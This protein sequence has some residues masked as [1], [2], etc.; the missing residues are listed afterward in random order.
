LTDT[1]KVDGVAF[2]L[3][4]SSVKFQMRLETSPTLK[5]N[6]T[7]QI[8]LATAGTVRYDWAAIDVD[9]AGTYIGWWE[10]TLA[11]G[12]TQN[13]P[14]FVLVVKDADPAQILDYVDR[15]DLKSTL[16]LQGFTYADAD[17]DRAISAA[18]RGIDEVT[19]RR[20]Y[21]DAD[22]LQVRYYTPRCS[23]NLWID[24][25]I[26]L[27]SLKTDQNGDGTFEITWTLTTDFLLEPLNAILNGRPFNHV[28]LAERGTKRFYNYRRS[29]E[30]TGKFG[31]SSPPEAVKTATGL[32]AARL[33]RRMREAPFG[34]V[35]V[36]LEGEAVHISRFDPDVA[37]LL[38]PYTQFQSFQ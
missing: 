12:K 34:V 10:V 20:F 2:D 7:A 1:I 15:E 19:S 31:W 32:V 8:V 38:G 29:V 14:A 6:A 11:S 13:T 28:T 35:Q 30:L 18:S 5:V 23:D 24:D 36:G 9:T 21:P 25:L 3:T 26:T 4:G 16:S 37:F 33:L 17:I 27:T 22:A